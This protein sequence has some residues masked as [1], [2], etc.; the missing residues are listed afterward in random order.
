MEIPD[1]TPMNDNSIEPEPEPGPEPE[2]GE[3][4]E[5]QVMVRGR[6]LQQQFATTTGAKTTASTTVRLPGLNTPCYTPSR[7]KISS[8]YDQLKSV[9]NSARA[10]SERRR[11][12]QKAAATK[13][14]AESSIIPVDSDSDSDDDDGDAFAEDLSFQEWL[15]DHADTEFTNEESVA[16]ASA[17]AGGDPN[18][19]Q[20][21]ENFSAAH[22]GDQHPEA[23]SKIIQSQVHEWY[24]TMVRHY[25]G[26]QQENANTDG[27]CIKHTETD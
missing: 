14:L 15:Y 21:N 11:L 16:E 20:V 17:A 3:E 18:G 5:E 19:L 2:E 26:T 7:G 22:L 1:A 12:E 23:S 10:T 9:L 24:N 8:E 13:S 6:D 4:R 25:R 27:E